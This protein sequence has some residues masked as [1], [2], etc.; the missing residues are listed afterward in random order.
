MLLP[1]EEPMDSLEKE[2][3]EYVREGE[4]LL[5]LKDWMCRGKLSTN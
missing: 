3:K 1:F 2:G 5:R 4:E